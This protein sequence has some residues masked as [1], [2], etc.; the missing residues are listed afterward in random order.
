MTNTIY[1]RS[2]IETLAKTENKSLQYWRAEA[3]KVFTRHA[4]VQQVEIVQTGRKTDSTLLVKS[5]RRLNRPDGVAVIIAST[6][7]KWGRSRVNLVPYVCPK[8]QFI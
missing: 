3:K 4:D 6:G 1:K 7:G 2:T 5:G 8:G